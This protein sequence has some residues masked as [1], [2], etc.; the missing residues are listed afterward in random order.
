[1]GTK[2]M[3]TKVPNTHIQ[4]C[5]S[6]V[7]ISSHKSAILVLSW[8]QILQWKHMSTTYVALVTTTSEESAKSGISSVKM[9]QRPLYRHLFFQGWILVT[10]FSMEL[11]LTLFRNSRNTAARLVYRLPK[12]HHIFQAL[13][14]LYWLPVEARIVFKILCIVYKCLESSSA[15]YLQDLL[16]PCTAQRQLRSSDQNFLS[17]PK[18]KLA[19]FGKRAFSKSAPRLWNE[20]PQ[21]LR[22]IENFDTFK[23][24]LK[25]YLFCKYYM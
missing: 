13:V 3:L 15:R 21:N 14:S 8:I 6:S 10:V 22:D 20:L 2:S 5:S 25:T 16:V 9:Q 12:Y 19:S 11:I 4:I 24:N 23:K 17:V 7:Q 18:F 1:M